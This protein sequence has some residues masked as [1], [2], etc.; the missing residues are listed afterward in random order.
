MAKKKAK[1]TVKKVASKKVAVAKKSSKKSG[2]GLAIVALI[3]NVLILP[4]LGSLIGS[5]TRAGI[6]QIVLVIIGGILA[7]FVPFLGVIAF[8][9]W[10]WG[11]VTGI[12][13]IQEARR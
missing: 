11:L 1:K 13:L 6:W 4:G 5:K 9:G 2:M 7:W 10:I 8:V 3:L 12:T